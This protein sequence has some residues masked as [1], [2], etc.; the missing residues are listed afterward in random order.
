VQAGQIIGFMGNTGNSVFPHLQFEMHPNAG[1]AINA[2]SLL[3]RS[4]GCKTGE[5]YRQP[6]GWVPD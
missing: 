4:R 3:R 2:Y 1:G 5:Q 6:S